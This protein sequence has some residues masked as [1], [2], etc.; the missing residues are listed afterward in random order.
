MMSQIRKQPL[1]NVEQIGDDGA[2]VP[3]RWNE[4]CQG[5]LEP[6]SL[7]L[8]LPLPHHLKYWLLLKLKFLILLYSRLA[9]QQN[10]IKFPQQLS[11][12]TCK[13]R[14]D[15]LKKI[16]NLPSVANPCVGDEQFLQGGVAGC[17]ATASWWLMTS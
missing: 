17:A 5:C 7:A 6:Y 11:D 16:Q 3:A 12:G 8:F 4:I 10:A 13:H 15:L 9:R 14:M 1:A 2:G